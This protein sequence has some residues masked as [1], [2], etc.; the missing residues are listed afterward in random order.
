M[1]D[2]SVCACAH[3]P[4]ISHDGFAVGLMNLMPLHR[5]HDNRPVFAW[6]IRKRWRDENEEKVGED[7]E[8]DFISICNV[9]L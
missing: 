3:V 5:Y 8:F 1:N 9:I 4:L 2:D 7:E 6:R